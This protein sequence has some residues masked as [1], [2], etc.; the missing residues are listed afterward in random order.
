MSQ[1]LRITLPVRQALGRGDFY[2]AEANS[3]A[4]SQIECWRDWPGRKLVLAGPEGSGKTHLAHV[5]ASES[6]AR[7]LEA[8]SLTVEDVPH[9][10]SGPLCIEDVPAVAGDDRAER[11]L[12]HLH[13]LALAEGQTLLLTADRPPSNWGL[14]LPDLASRMNGTP[15]VSLSEP[16]DL[17]LGAVLLK[18]FADRQIVPA[19]DAVTYLVR[20]MHRSFAMAGQIV[21]AL[22]EAALAQP[23]GINRPLAIKVLQQLD[24]LGD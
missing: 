3:V 12:L 1:Q 16:D 9:L 18:M 2:V 5:W 6:G 10:V 20:H 4:V 11:A 22:D 24:T 19:P 17:L 23:K 8:A 7:I 21:D 13:N 14:A 15:M